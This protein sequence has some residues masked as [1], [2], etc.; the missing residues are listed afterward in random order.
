MYAVS[1][2]YSSH[3]IDLSPPRCCL[4]P[5]LLSPGCWGTCSVCGSFS[6]G[7]GAPGRWWED[8]QDW[9]EPDEEFR[10]SSLIQ[11]IYI[12]KSMSFRSS[13]DNYCSA[14]II[15]RVYLGSLFMVYNI[16]CKTWP[17]CPRNVS[18]LISYVLLLFLT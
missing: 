18:H 9:C 14:V 7:C 5:R 15:R 10:S 13:R 12:N 17:H 6:A 3:L 2:G 8:Y 4:P 11:Q 16:L 1:D